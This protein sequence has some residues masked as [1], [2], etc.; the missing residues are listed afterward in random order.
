MGTAH[1]VWWNESW[2]SSHFSGTP[3]TFEKEGEDF[4]KKIIIGDETWVHHYHPGYKRQSMEFRH[5]E[6]PQPKK[7]KT[8][9]SAGKVM[10]TVFWNSERVVLADFHEK[11]RCW[12]WGPMCPLSIRVALHSWRSI[13]RVFTSTNRIHVFR[14]LSV[15]PQCN[16]FPETARTTDHLARTVLVCC[17]TF[18]SAQPLLLRYE[19]VPEF[20]WTVTSSQ[21]CASEE[22]GC[23]L[24]WLTFSGSESSWVSVSECVE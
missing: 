14:S 20:V 12:I 3:G 18:D 7:F 19:E 13:I 9:A 23:V 5:K 21:R 16:A 17:A 1:A 8:Q 24:E 4:W 15:Y 10:L 22:E 6:S 11:E 2:K